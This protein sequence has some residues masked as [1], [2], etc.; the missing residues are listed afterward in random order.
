VKVSLNAVE[1]RVMHDREFR[2]ENSRQSLNQLPIAVYET[3]W[4][5]ECI[6]VNPRW[7]Q[8][9]GLSSEESLGHGWHAIV[10]PDDFKSLTQQ[11]TSERSKEQAYSVEYRIITVTG[12]L[13][14]VHVDSTVLHDE[15]GRA[16]GRIGTVADV[17]ERMNTELRIKQSELKYRSLIQSALD[18][19]VGADVLGNIISWNR[20]AET[21]FQ[22]TEAEAVGQSLTILIP[23]RFRSQHLAGM[24]RVA[25]LGESKMAGKVVKLV[26]LRKDGS[27]FPLEMAMSTWND[28]ASLFFTSILRDIS[29]REKAQEAL[30]AKVV[31]RTS[32]FAALSEFIPQLVWTMSA[33]GESLFFNKR[34]VDYT[35]FGI[36]QPARWEDL[37]HSEDIA[38]AQAAWVKS[39]QTGDTYEIEYRLK[40]TDGQFRWHLNRAFAVKNSDGEVS[41]WFGTSTDI[42]DQKLAQATVLELK[43][44]TDSVIQNAPIALSAI[45]QNGIFTFYDGKLGKLSGIRSTDR[46]GQSVYAKY[47]ESPRVIN[48]FE[49]ALGG[50]S[51]SLETQ[52]ENVYVDNKFTPQYDAAGKISGVVILSLDITEKKSQELERQKSEEIFQRARWGMA[53]I[54]PGN[55]FIQ[56]NPAFAKM[57]GTT[58]AYWI[59]RPIRDMFPLESSVDLPTLMIELVKNG[60][61]T[62]ESDHLHRAGSIFPCLADV[63]E[64][65]NEQGELLYR[66][67][68]Y[69][70]LTELKQAENE[71]ASASVQAQGALAASKLKSEFLANMS[72]EIR[73]PI[74]GVMGMTSLLL[75]T[76]LS[77][78][79]REYANAISASADNLLLLVN[80]ILD[81]SKAE[82]GKVE[83]EVIDFEL[84]HLINGVEKVLT[85][86]ARG[87]G[88]K[89]F[90]SV[91]PD[92]VKYI[93]GDPTRLQQILVNLVNNAIKFTSK[94]QV[95]I[96]ARLANEN[97]LIPMIRF[98]IS[99]TGIG[100]S[101][102]VIGRLFTPFAQADSSTTRKFGGSGLGLSICKHLVHSMG[103]EIGVRSEEN[104]GSTFW[105]SIPLIAGTKQTRG[106]RRSDEPKFKVPKLRILVADD[107]SVNQL[108]A[109]KMLEAMG[110][111][112]VIVANGKEAIDALAVAPYDLVLMDCQMP[113][114]DG[115]EATRRIRGGANLTCVDIEIIAMTANAMK[116]DREKCLEAGMNN[117]IS[118]PMKSADLAGVIAESVARIAAA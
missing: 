4:T 48:A 39:M 66:V 74:N 68:N 18:A 26:G 73:T 103:G 40:A 102:L 59:D 19:V 98:E 79:Q 12:E 20:G 99:D 92:L 2:L 64:V 76:P 90:K 69:I 57:H 78:D 61:L 112:V 85:L 104:T 93:K 80:D 3:N 107:N 32:D 24:A 49:R 31:E 84:G 15:A 97:P 28:G 33:A 56:V 58:Q 47:S 117:Y 42:H 116:G 83:L 46:V 10:H 16:I 52:D 109:R 6:Y 87:K 77:A 100:I 94:G 43:Q 114:L 54:A 101:P 71:R 51:L 82:A 1:G 44:R 50:E 45:D 25:L 75:D 105:F 88:L 81:L 70:D 7:T 62:F 30:E 53:V 35:G 86:P 37:L 34:W 60:H 118:K 65:K 23:E 91:D 38:S 14:W 115:Y 11:V 106:R 96:E 72:H 9:C 22:Y 17:T 27:E 55:T 29:E 41:K 95:T 108:I 110:H 8:L 111:N 89:L 13:K 113:E 67:A 36:G 63:T 5:G 21:S